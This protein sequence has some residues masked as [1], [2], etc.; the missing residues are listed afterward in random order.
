MIEYEGPPQVLGHC[1][2]INRY[3]EQ[4]I[5]NTYTK[6]LK[7]FRSFYVGE[8]PVLTATLIGILIRN[9][10]IELGRMGRVGAVKRIK[11]ANRRR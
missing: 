8:H 10:E 6:Q 1:P 3:G 5:V 4:N 9:R 11:K 2:E 7:R